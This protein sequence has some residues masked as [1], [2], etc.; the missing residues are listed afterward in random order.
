L[1][2]ERVVGRLALE[3]LQAR[4]VV[5]HPPLVDRGGGVARHRRAQLARLG[6]LVGAKIAWASG[7]AA[8]TCPRSAA[9]RSS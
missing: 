1:A 6:D 2:H 4:L 8:A 7:P 3:H 9:L 5:A